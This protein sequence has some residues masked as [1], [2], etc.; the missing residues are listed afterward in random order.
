MLT[1]PRFEWVRPASARR[2]ARAARRAR[3]PRACS[4]RAAPTWCRTSST[5]CTSRATS[6]TSAALR[7]LRVVRDEADGLHLGP[8]VTLTRA[9]RASRGRARDFPALAQGGRARR[10]AAAPQHG[11][12]RRQPLPR[13]ALHLL[14]PDATSGARRS[15][16]ASRR[17]APS[18][19]WC[20][21]GKRCVA[22]HSS[23]VAPVL[24][25]LGA[26]VE[27]AGPRAGARIAG[28]RVLRRRRHPQ[29]RAR[30]RRAGDA[31][32]RAGALRAACAAATRSCARAA[33]STS[34]CCRWRSPRASSGGAVRGGA[35]GGERD[36]APSRARS[37]AS[38][39]SCAGA[40]LDDDGRRG[41]RRRRAYKQCHPLINVPYDQDYRREMVPVFVRRAVREAPGRRERERSASAAMEPRTLRRR[42]ERAPRR[43]RVG[44]ARA[45]AR[46]A[47]GGSCSP[48]WSRRAASRRARPAPTCWSAADGET[49]GTIGGGAI[50]HEVLASARGAARGAAAPAHGASATSRRSSACAA[51]AR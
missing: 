7:E 20:R 41:A 22:A 17:T 27:I 34:R 37:A 16:S 24:I 48:P 46:R 31:R 3:R 40:P 32:L 14:Q 42:R 44:G 29:Q 10:R 38:T 30:A 50:E 43:R 26:E 12:A 36:R 23:D 5:A 33:R 51:A 49:V 8:L 15:A 39:R 25:A 19:T 35:A 13:H 47:A 4:S 28:R 6:F 9:A 18:A 21:T 2:A 1:L 11:H 45:L